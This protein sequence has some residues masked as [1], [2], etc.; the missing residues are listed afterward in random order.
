M[1]TIRFDFRDLDRVLG[2]ITSFVATDTM[3]TI[4]PIVKEDITK[5]TA[6]G[7]DA[8][9]QKFDAY[10]ED[11]AKTRA[12]KNLQVTPV[13]LKVTGNLL[14]SISAEGNRISVPQELEGQAEG[15]MKKRKWLGVGAKTIK[16]I[17]TALARAINK[18]Q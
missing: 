2:R 11:Y 6:A 1:I 7:D 5:R 17:E 3:K 13:N 4:A 18:L 16:K 9:D 8:N 10:T 14:D 15:L 12:K